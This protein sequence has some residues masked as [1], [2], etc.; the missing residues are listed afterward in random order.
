MSGTLLHDGRRTGHLGWCVRAITAGTA[1][2]MFISPFS[3]P[4]IGQVRNPSGADAS[5]AAVTAGGEV[6][7]DAST[8]ALFLPGVNKRDFYDT[9]ELW[10]PSGIGLDSPAR[11]IEHIERVFGRQTELNTPRLAPTMTLD[12]PVSGDAALALETARVARGT[13]RGCWQTLAGTRTFWASGARLDAYVGSL[14]ALRSPTWVLNMVNEL[15]VDNVPD[16]ANT[17][18]FEG[19]CRTVHSLSARSRVIVAY[20][21]F[22][23]L[24]AVAAGADTVGTGWDRSQ[25]TFDPN[26][27]RVNSDPGI[28]IPAS[29]VTQGGVSAVLRRDTAN[30]IDRWDPVQAPVIR[31]GAMPASDQA[32]WFHHLERLQSTALSIDGLTLKAD[33]VA[34]LRA[35]YEQAL[36]HFNAM[37]AGL[38]NVVRPRDKASWSEAPLEVL[39]AYA[40]AEGLW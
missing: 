38:P 22:A 21:D 33:R 14:A 7:F 31:G 16:L 26:Y 2:G 40:S 4:R 1:N 28:R 13:D 25:R 6:L 29:Y 23:A 9:W 30:A 36:V 18:A 11:R 35:H 8:H 27:F 24:P 5:A 19:L 12:S 34:W 15:V 39:R 3:T 20:G 17:A 32:E 10:G 37:I